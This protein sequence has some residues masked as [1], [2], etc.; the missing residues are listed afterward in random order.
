[1]TWSLIKQ[2]GISSPYGMRGGGFHSGLDVPCPMNTPLP[3]PFAGV[4]QYEGYIPPAASGYSNELIIILQLDGKFVVL[5]HLSR[6]TVSAGQRVSVGQV[7]GYSGNSG[8]VLPKPT[9][10]NPN[11]GAH[12]HIEMRQG[13][14]ASNKGLSAY[15]PVDITPYL[16]TKEDEVT[17]EENFQNCYITQVGNWPTQAQV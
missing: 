16:Q 10:A 1:M 6:T 5:G 17:R 4:V 2:H 8:Y 14:K 7:I 15:T 11:S 9:S 12:L 13:A 3:S